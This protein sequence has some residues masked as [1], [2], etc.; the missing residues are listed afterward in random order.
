MLVASA[1]ASACSSFFQ[2]SPTEENG[3]PSAQPADKPV[4]KPAPKPEKK[5][6]TEPEKK[7]K[8]E[9]LKKP[10]PQPV[11]KTPPTPPAITTPPV[12]APLPPETPRLEPIYDAP[13]LEPT[14]AGS[15]SAGLARLV[16]AAALWDVVRLFHPAVAADGQEWDNLTVRYVTDVR[17][18]ATRAQYA[19]VMQE[20]LARLNDPLT[21]LVTASPAVAAAD[22]ET[23]PSAMR[24][25]TQVVVTGSKKIRVSDTT[26]VFSWPDSRSSRDSAAWSSLGDAIENNLQATQII[27]DLRTR[28]APATNAVEI[29]DDVGALQLR[30]ANALIAVPTTSWG[31]RRRVYEGWPDARPGVTS[32]AGVAA[33]RVS[34]PAVRVTP[35]YM[36]APLRRVVIIADSNTVMAP[37]MMALVSSRQA[38]LVVEGALSDVYMVPVTSVALGQGLV[39]QIR[40]GELINVDGNTGLVPDTTVAPAAAATDSAPAMRAAVQIARGLLSPSAPVAANRGSIATVPVS[41]RRASN[42]W[43]AAHY[44]IMG[45]RVLSAFRMWGTLRTFHAYGDLRDESIDD[46]LLRFLPR[47]EAAADAFAYH[48]TMLEFASTAG[49]A[50]VVMTSPV[51]NQYL[52]TAGAPFAVRWVADHAI[53]TQVA[54]DD[55]GRATGIVV[56]DEITAADGYPMP[57][58]IT[59]HRRYSAASNEWTRHRNSMQFIPRGA[60]GNASY[61]VR[62]ASNRERAVTITRDSAHFAFPLRSDRATTSVMRELTGGIGYL[63]LDRATITQIDSAFQTLGKTRALILDARGRG[64]TNT[65]ATFTP[66][67]VTALRR[68][69]AQSSA[70]INRQTVRVAGEPCAPSDSRLVTTSCTL[71]QRQFEGISPA[72]T[73]GHYRGRV[74]VL[75]DERT[76]GAMEQFALGAERVANATFIGSSSAGASGAITSMILPGY[77]TLTFTGIEL[78]HADGQQL[79]RVGITPQVEVLPTA[80]GIRGRNDEV[81]ER[82]QQWLL[83]QLDP[84]V[85]RRR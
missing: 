49:D 83:Q 26:H 72:D 53:V 73:A 45:A 8:L 3:T 79:Q 66:E 32:P 35:A 77:I 7:P 82:A 75:V 2:L 19:T 1:Y 85:R 29:S 78:R 63:D 16:H 46:A 50:Q 41:M 71:E 84:T 47:L 24:E 76:Q 39:A 36:S 13:V 69:A 34:D 17:T 57:A 12:T 27:L 59:E 68:I 55:A 56:G 18:A 81:L 44:P 51:L 22:D 67:L 54:D 6:K 30:V 5:P 65:T 33:W 42:E 9:P 14:P 25:E 80:K 52:G 48:A 4:E 11:Q 10:K 61:K 74:V 31:I 58:Y 62:D 40:T 70:V 43:P 60:P 64:R 23:G 20:W 37:A 21:H 28:R 38:T 15:D